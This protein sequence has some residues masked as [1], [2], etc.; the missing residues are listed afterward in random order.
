MKKIKMFLAMGSLLV[1][2]A[3]PAQEK[4]NT[5]SYK[6]GSYEIILLSEGE[7]TGNS[8]ILIDATD[9]ILAKYTQDGAF[10]NATNAF[11]IKTLDKNILIDT[12]FGR[13]LF[14]NMAKYGVRA[15]DIDIVLITHMHGDHIGGMMHDGKKAFP[16]AELYLPQGEYDYWTSLDA[17]NSQP[18]KRRGG[19]L[20]AKKVVETYKDKLHLFIPDEIGEAP[21]QIIPG[22]NAVAAYGHT[23]GHTVYMIGSGKGR[24]LVWGDLT[25]AMAVQMPH[26]EI[27]VTYDVDPTQAIASRKKILEYVSEN[28]IPIA[29]MHI[30]Y[31]AIGNIAPGND[32]GYRFIP[33]SVK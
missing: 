4:Q 28:N 13:N 19:F 6:A 2:A 21:Q 27:A 29:G 32:R 22:I 5:F 7:Q 33:A 1:S 26:P 12:G 30:A 8:G 16:N 9:E 3:L 31:P 11:L 14:D 15:E 23:P 10:P 20:N 18:E 17:M 24:T 25:H